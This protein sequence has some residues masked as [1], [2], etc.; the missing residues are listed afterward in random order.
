MVSPTLGRP[1]RRQTIIPWRWEHPRQAPMTRENLQDEPSP[2]A[3]LIDPLMSP[4]NP[5]RLKQLK[6][7]TPWRRDHPM[8]CRAARPRMPQWTKRNPRTS[9]STGNASLRQ[10]TIPKRPRT[11]DG[12]E[13][14][15]P[16]ARSP[17]PSR[18]VFARW[19]GRGKRRGSTPR[20]RERAVS[21]RR[22][23][24]RWSRKHALS[25]SG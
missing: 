1:R 16:L 12:I 18:G 4:L 20:V 10:R 23:W 11:S 21:S 3:R 19:R 2:G 7:I 14:G 15:S 5:A 24:S 9:T 22:R 17:R 6:T 13:R 25:Q 8:S